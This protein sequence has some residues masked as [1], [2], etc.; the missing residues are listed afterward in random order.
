MTFYDLCQDILAGF[1]ATTGL[2]SGF[3]SSVVS[4]DSTVRVEKE[5]YHIDYL[6][7][8]IFIRNQSVEF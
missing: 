5:I 3:D 7:W 2:S 8:Y 1:P 4:E 6:V